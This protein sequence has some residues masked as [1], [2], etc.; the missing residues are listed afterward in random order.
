MSEPRTILI[1]EDELTHLGVME[2]KLKREGYN[3]IS[4]TDGEQ[5]YHAIK[6]AKPD[7]VL[8][9]IMLPKMNGF[10]VLENLRKDNINIPV[11]IVS[12]SGQPVEIDK[13]LKLG[14]RDYLVKTEFNPSDVLDKV[15]KVLGES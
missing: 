14:A 9:D 4:A 15:K 5:G 1:I 12:N 2:T 7:L 3:V 8:L 6:E 10:D 11:V 13:A